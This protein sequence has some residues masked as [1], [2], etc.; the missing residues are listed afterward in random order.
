[1]ISE[2]W[3]LGLAGTLLALGG[4][5]VGVYHAERA[6]SVPITVWRDLRARL[7]WRGFLVAVLPPVIWIGLFYGLVLWF[8]VAG[9]GWPEFGTTPSGTAGVLTEV[10]WAVLV[11][12]LFA[13]Y[14]A[15]VVFFACLFH[16]RARPVSVYCLAF[17]A[18]ALLAW[19]LSSLAPGPFLNWF[20]D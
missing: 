18:A 11:V 20:L 8:V 19:G 10:V 9:E 6:L 7:T 3:L 1:M 14:A 16:S 5:S 2:P 4:Y 13:L 17:L 12:N 15:P